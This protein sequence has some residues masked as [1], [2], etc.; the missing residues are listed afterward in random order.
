L[1]LS[2][3]LIWGSTWLAITFQLGEVDPLASVIYRM[4]IGSALLFI[5]CLLR[6]I[7]LGV[8]PLN[9]AFFIA[10]G[11]LLFGLNFWTIYIAE[12]YLTSGIVAVIF[13]LLVF[14]NIINGRIFLNRPVSAKTLIGGLLGML[15]VG[16]L[17]YPEILKYSSSENALIG[18]SMAVLSVLIASLGNITA[19]R[20]G[21]T[22]LSVWSINAWA[23]L[24]GS[25][26][27]SIIAL[28]SGVEFSYENTVEYTASLIYLSVFGTVLVFGAYLK[29]LISIG[30]ER[31]A[32]ASLVIPFVAIALSTIFEGYQWT[33][34]AV[35]GFAVVVAGNFM[36]VVKPLTKT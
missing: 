8:S 32:F 6:K 3:I 20:N 36:V 13:S 1:Y 19:T 15:G 11:G 5:W 25:L 2:T 9:H 30:P 14:F 17:F 26:I 27:L 7:P 16:M 21:Q 18:F 24:Y 22:G 33:P 28:L 10:Q 35:I 34:I 31:A 23:M 4:T 12:V 29:L